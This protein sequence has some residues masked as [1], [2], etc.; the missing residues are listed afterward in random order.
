MLL[1]AWLTAGAIGPDVEFPQAVGYM[2]GMF[3]LVFW[4]APLATAAVTLVL[5]QSLF[6]DRVKAGKSP[7][8][9]SLRYP[10]CCST[11]CCCGGS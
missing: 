3:L 6:S 10:K 11:R 1:N 7:A 4:E 8:T 9:S 5:G 2:Y